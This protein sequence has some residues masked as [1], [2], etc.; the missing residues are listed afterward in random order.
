[1]KKFSIIAFVVLAA[2]SC[3]K[4][5]TPVVALPQDPDEVF[6]GE[7]RI[8][9][10]FGS[11]IATLVETKAAVTAFNQ[12]QDLHI[13]GIARDG[14]DNLNLNNIIIDDVTSKSPAGDGQIYVE[15]RASGTYY[16]YQYNTNYSFFGYYIDNITPRRKRTVGNEIALDLSIDGS[17]DVMVARDNRDASVADFLDTPSEA[18]DKYLASYPADTD[19]SALRKRLYSAYSARKGITPEL[20]FK[21]VLSRFVF[22][23]VDG[24][25]NPEANLKVDSLWIAGAKTDATLYVVSESRSGAACLVPSDAQTDNL[26]LLDADGNDVLN[27]TVYHG[28]STEPVQL[29]ESLMAMPGETS[30]N[31]AFV[32]KQDEVNG[33]TTRT[34]RRVQ[35]AVINMPSGE[36]QPGVSYT[37]NIT[38]Y[39]LEKIVLDVSLEPWDAYDTPIN[40]GEDD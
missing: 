34:V 25:V 21:H 36:S 23:I 37:V 40:I 5:E 12:N 10:T 38:V 3:S 20:R 32:L 18:L 7:E 2:F 26:Y 27:H 24:S 11:D 15:D 14:N 4:Q 16:Y 8:P 33:G 1:M 28:G 19:G 6:T 13:Y 35:T 39:S 29:G 31:L 17:Q 22:H 9:I 30:Y